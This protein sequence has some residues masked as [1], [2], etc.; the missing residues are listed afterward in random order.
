MS[1]A[2][3]AIVD[4]Q[5]WR[6]APDELRTR[7]KAATRELDAIAATEQLGHSFGLIDI[8]PWG[9]REKWLDSP[10]GWPKRPT[11]S[12]WA[13][14]PSSPAP[15]DLAVVGVGKCQPPSASTDSTA[16]SIGSITCIAA[17]APLKRLA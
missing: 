8:L 7:E 10:E 4:N 17:A 3:G 1:N 6:A 2:T 11:Y 5:T 16:R 12:G 13:G 9:R 14:V 15:A